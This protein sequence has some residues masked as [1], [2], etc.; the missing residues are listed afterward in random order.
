LLRRPNPLDELKRLLQQREAAYLTAD[1][2][3]DVE[4]LDPQRVAD[5]VAPFVAPVTS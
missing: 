2:V 3:I 1:H 4:A 5:A